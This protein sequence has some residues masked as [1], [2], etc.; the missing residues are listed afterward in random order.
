MS[1][2]HS[3]YFEADQN[4][5]DVAQSPGF[6]HL[7]LHPTIVNP[8]RINEFSATQEQLLLAMHL[9]SHQLLVISNKSISIY[10][11]PKIRTGLQKLGSGALN[12][13]NGELDLYRV[14]VNLSK[15]VK[16]WSG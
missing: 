13:E 1:T 4:L 11:I 9:Q 14:S 12:G 8:E 16:L 6:P 3:I 7:R 10:L 2:D 15:Q 5:R